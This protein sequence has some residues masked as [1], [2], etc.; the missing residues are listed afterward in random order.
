MTTVID[1]E[2]KSVN[3]KEQRGRTGRLG[4]VRTDGNILHCV[5]L[6]GKEIQQ[7]GDIC[8]CVAGSLCYAVEANTTL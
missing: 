7:A 1:I 4:L 5:D 2:N 8:I 6:N 3:T